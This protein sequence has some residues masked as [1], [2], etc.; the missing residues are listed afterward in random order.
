M[1]GLTCSRENYSFKQYINYRLTLRAFITK[2]RNLHDA[3]DQLLFQQRDLVLMIEI[4][5][6]I[7]H[8]CGD[9]SVLPHEISKTGDLV[10]IIL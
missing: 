8:E 1:M 7:A 4:L 6:V 3:L 9:G 5:E 2:M 10:F